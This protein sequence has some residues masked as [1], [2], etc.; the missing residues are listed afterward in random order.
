MDTHSLQVDTV[1]NG[2][3]LKAPPRGVQAFWSTGKRKNSC[4]FHRL[5]ITRLVY[6]CYLNT[7]SVPHDYC[8]GSRELSVK[9]TSVAKSGLTASRC[10][11]EEKSRNHI[12]PRA[13]SSGTVPPGPQPSRLPNDVIGLWR[14]HLFPTNRRGVSQMRPLEYKRVRCQA[15]APA[16]RATDVEI[17]DFFGVDVEPFHGWAVRVCHS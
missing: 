7:D 16:P 3:T 15:A 4:C 14:Q 6:L 10:S 17:T 5:L 12:Q 1:I 9:P 2:N 8:H 13:W 11:W